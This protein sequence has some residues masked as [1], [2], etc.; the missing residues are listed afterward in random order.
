LPEVRAHETIRSVP[1][2]GFH[3]LF[4]ATAGVAGTL[5][6]LL[7][8]AIS[9]A[10]ERLTAQDSAQAHRVRASAA[11]TAFT[12]AL[13]VSLFVL[14][15]GIGSGWPALVV[16]VMGLLFVVSSLLSARSP[17]WWSCAS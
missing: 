11:L 17:S 6:G 14:V 10:H 15:P 7:F 3:D 9:V 8:V 2:P 1:L 4:L 12:N 16:A 5:I 13:S